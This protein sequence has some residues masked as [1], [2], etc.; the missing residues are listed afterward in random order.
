MP[1][2]HI[3]VELDDDQDEVLLRDATEKEIKKIAKHYA[4]GKALMI[5]NRIC[6]ADS[7]RKFTIVKTEH[8]L[9]SE[10]EELDRQWELLTKELNQNPTSSTFY[11]MI[12]PESAIVSAGTDVTEQFLT[13]TPGYDGILTS[14]WSFLNSNTSAQIIAGLIV[15]AISYW[16]AK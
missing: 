1:Y 10:I 15:A 5:S 12:H 16:L 6:A 4:S 14:I 9:V 8:Q 13:K 7:V 3:V 11:P 2:F